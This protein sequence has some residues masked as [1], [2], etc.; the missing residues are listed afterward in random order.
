[1]STIPRA[2]KQDDRR[3]PKRDRSHEL[4][5][6]AVEQFAA[7]GYAPVTIKDIAN[8]IGVNTGVIYY[9]Y[10]S[11]EALFGA[12]V[13]HLVAFSLQQYRASVADCDEPKELL[14]RWFDV[15]VDNLDVVNSLMKI[16]YD[17]TKSDM[18]IDGADE[19]IRQFYDEE[20][21]FLISA[22]KEG[23]R[24]KQFGAVNAERVALFISTHL[25]GIVVRSA[26]QP[27]IDAAAAIKELRETIWGRLGCT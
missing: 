7:R 17:Y 14:T 12:A 27:E 22:I 21:K 4:L 18:R 6:S 10:S 9:Y 8:Q 11:K 3:E 19:A 5:L 16:M 1:M 24:R 25:D 13:E 15:V 23:I 26:I 20:R 2:R